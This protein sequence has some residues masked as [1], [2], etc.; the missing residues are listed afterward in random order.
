MQLI[1]YLSLLLFATS[2]FGYSYL[3]LKVVFTLVLSPLILIKNSHY[4]T[5]QNNILWGV[6]ITAQ[7]VIFNAINFYSF[8]YYSQWHYSIIT[9]SFLIFVVG[10]YT[11]RNNALLNKIVYYFTLI[12]A[13][14]S[15]YAI[16]EY[17]GFAGVVQHRQFPPEISGSI[18]HKNTFGFIIMVSATCCYYNLT[19]KKDEKK[20]ENVFTAFTFLTNT[21]ALIISDSRWAQFLALIGIGTITLL[22]FRHKSSKA[23]LKPFFLILAVIP[24]LFTLPDSTKLRFKQAF[25]DYSRDTFRISAYS[26]QKQMFSEK[27]LLGNGL[28]YFA[29]HFLPYAKDD[30]RRTNG[31]QTVFT[32]HCEPLQRLA[33][34]GLIG[35]LLYYFWVIGALFIFL[36]KYGQSKKTEYFLG[37][38]ILVLMILHSLLSGAS[39][40]PPASF[41]LWFTTGLAWSFKMVRKSSNTPSVSRRVLIIGI[42]IMVVL[43]LITITRII[44]SDYYLEIAKT[45]KLNKGISTT[46]EALYKENLEKSLRFF[47]GNPHSRL[48]ITKELLSSNT[49]EARRE[50]LEQAKLLYTY[51]GTALPSLG[52][53]GHAYLEN[54]IMDSAYLY[55]NSS[56]KLRPSV[57]NGLNL[58]ARV[59][60]ETSNFDALEKHISAVY[61]K[62]DTTQIRS[63]LVELQKRDDTGYFNYKAG[64]IRSKFHGRNLISS[65][66]HDKKLKLNEKEEE[67]EQLE[68]LKY[69]ENYTNTLK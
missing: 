56:T 36:S 39:T 69:L 54:Q 25:T 42:T 5:P 6:F 52:I 60:F 32:G 10:I 51:A 1:I 47:T 53:L 68:Y 34:L 3:S 24:L 7:L 31:L 38:T 43:P 65:L 33:E 61:S 21:I 8:T 37:C 48:E 29:A 59:L 63:T 44:V 49:P 45:H 58:K 23:S 57:I 62:F 30:F 19:I 28:G 46:S 26:A 40:K 12:S 16:T 11:G 18:G 14:A 50:S 4:L 22:L 64:K 67:L 20:T 41:L 2:S 35:S 15:L 66:Y 17:F 9:A 27:P 13:V 55:I